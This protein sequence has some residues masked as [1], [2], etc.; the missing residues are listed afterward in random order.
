M[1]CS[2]S[3]ACR[4]SIVAVWGVRAGEVV[5]A[6][7]RRDGGRLVVLCNRCRGHVEVDE[8]DEVSIELAR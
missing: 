6:E 4:W 3:S 7:G 1:G 2:T 5:M 8:M